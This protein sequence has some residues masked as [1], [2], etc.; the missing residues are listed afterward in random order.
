M[1]LR[2]I[3]LASAAL[4]AL[5]AGV[6]TAIADEQD[7]AVRQLNLEQLEKARSDDGSAQTMP[8][9]SQQDGMGGPEFSAP[10]GPDEGMT[11]DND[12]GV[13][14]EDALPPDSDDPDGDAEQPK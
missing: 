3:S 7:D 14:D 1:K 5:T 2:H 9:S 12:Q 11:D 6:G 8:A 10:P 4:L 13:D